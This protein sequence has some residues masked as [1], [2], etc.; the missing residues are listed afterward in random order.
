MP[1]QLYSYLVLHFKALARLPLAVI[2]W[3]ILF[4]A[5]V[6]AAITWNGPRLAAFWSAIQPRAT[7]FTSLALNHVNNLPT[8]AA[9][10]QLKFAFTIDNSEGRPMTYAYIVSVLRGTTSQIV[11]RGTVQ[12]AAGTQMVVPEHLIINGSPAARSLRAASRFQ[13]K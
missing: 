7:H 2:A 11:Q 12:L 8:V 4:G 13:A 6:A 10:G 3:V 9:D 1:S 5:L